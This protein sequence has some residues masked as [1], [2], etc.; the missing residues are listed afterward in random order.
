MV[1]SKPR[2]KFRG[3]TSR[4]NNF[5]RMNQ[6]TALIVDDEPLARKTIRL[7]LSDDSEIEVVGECGNG[8]DAVR[9]IKKL[10]PNLIFLAIQ[11]PEMDGFGVLSEISQEKPPVVV[12]VTAYDQ[13]AIKAFEFHALDY[14]LKPFDDDRFHKTVARAKIQVRQQDI[15]DLGK[16]LI[17]L[18]ETHTNNVARDRRSGA[19]KENAYL[20]RMM[21][22]ESGRVI[23]LK[24]GEIDWIEA[25]D[26]YAKIHVG[27]KSYLVRESLN[28]LEKQL[29]P[30][31]FLRIHRSSIVNLDCV[32][33]MHPLFKGDY[34]VV[35][36]DGTQLRL[37]RSRRGDLE[38]K[39][40][41]KR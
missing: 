28:D 12:F 4:S 18:V 29:N 3:I 21:I 27:K 20:T 36:I 15:D 13:Y 33:E 8:V 26:Y 39:V 14:L 16:R 31:K 25:A 5:S 34:A 7:L 30:S 32:K 1:A 11:M 35:L 23:F 9:Q 38:K 37:S 40:N 17:D 6:V 41:L 2:S 24:V 22:K 19:T 10:K